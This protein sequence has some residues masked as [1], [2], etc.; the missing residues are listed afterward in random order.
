[1]GGLIGL[2]GGVL[3]LNGG[4]LAL[5]EGGGLRVGWGLIVL[6]AGS[7]RCLGL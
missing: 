1:M 2:N 5:N 4:V 3:G 7:Q 6:N